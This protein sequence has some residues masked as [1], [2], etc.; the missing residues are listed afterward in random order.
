MRINNYLLR[1]WY[2]QKHLHFNKCREKKSAA[3]NHLD[4]FSSFGAKDSF[5]S[6]EIKSRLTQK[7][8]DRN[9]VKITA[10]RYKISIL[11]CRSNLFGLSHPWN[12]WL[13]QK[14]RSKSELA[15]VISCEVSSFIGGKGTEDQG[16]NKRGKV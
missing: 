12:V 10:F 3:K 2:R 8:E 14:E 13:Y 7:F 4:R 6:N 5:C 11:L 16:G 9:R 15:V 1:R